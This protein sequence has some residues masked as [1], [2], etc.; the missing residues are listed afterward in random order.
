[1][2]ASGMDKTKVFCAA[3]NCGAKYIKDEGMVWHFQTTPGLNN[4]AGA[5]PSDKDCCKK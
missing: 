4:S 2:W 3:L 1:M 5:L